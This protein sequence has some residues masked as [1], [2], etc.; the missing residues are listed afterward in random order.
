MELKSIIV[1]KFNLYK[2]LYKV[3]NTDRRSDVLAINSD[4]KLVGPQSPITPCG[5]GAVQHVWDPFWVICK[6]S[7][8]FKWRKQEKDRSD[9]ATGTG[10]LSTKFNSFAT[11][12]TSCKTVGDKPRK[13][14]ATIARSTA[15]CLEHQA[16]LRRVT[17]NDVQAFPHQKP[18]AKPT[19]QHRKADSLQ[20][21]GASACSCLATINMPGCWSS[22]LTDNQIK[23][24]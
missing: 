13:S 24:F 18:S 10:M 23:G 5:C 14:C 19:R 17:S 22:D 15:Y 11:S 20:R 2:V 16:S 3:P 6:R 1:K 8:V 21:K 9:S 12:F 7:H 4:I